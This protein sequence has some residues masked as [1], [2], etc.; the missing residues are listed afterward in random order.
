M[1]LSMAAGGGGNV[2][3]ID[4]S[5]DLKRPVDESAALC[6]IWSGHTWG[7]GKCPIRNF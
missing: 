2:V 3:L 1:G 5:R 7:R 4:P 6:L